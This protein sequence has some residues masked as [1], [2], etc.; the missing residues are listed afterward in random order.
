[1]EQSDALIAVDIGN[2][3]MK[4]GFYESGLM[5]DPFPLPDSICVEATSSFS[6]LFDW[7]DKQGVRFLHLHWMIASVNAKRTA[8]L[9]NW[10][11]RNRSRDQVQVLA[12]ADIPLK[13]R[14]D[15]PEKLGLDRAVAAYAAKEQLDYSGPI[16]VV[17]I[18]T[19][20]TI[21]LIDEEG[22]FVGGAILPG[23]QIAAQVLFE[24]TAQL[25][26]AG[27]NPISASQDPGDAERIAHYPASNTEM[28][29]ESGIR[30]SMIGSIYS[31][32]L[33][34]MIYLKRDARSL[35][36]I[37]IAERGNNLIEKPL[38]ELFEKGKSIFQ[39]NSIPP[40]ST[41]PYLILSGLALLHRK[42]F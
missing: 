37:L 29:I 32:Y 18:G 23:P 20:T 19:A 4:F 30:S 15:Y 36:P 22:T 25:P 40:I 24:K 39:G 13:I 3:F 38:R 31:F 11:K 33:D 5:K 16:L 34:S 26:H 12:L 10:L 42:S 7:L 28:G 21:D 8:S 6:D 1:M 2:S 14:Y 17:D 9:Q 41:S 27:W 35:F